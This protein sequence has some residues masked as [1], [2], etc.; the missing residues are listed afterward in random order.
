MLPS[1]LSKSSPSPDCGRG[2]SPIFCGGL[3]P[4]GLGG[5]AAFRREGAGGRAH[6]PAHMKQLS[7]NDA[8]EAKDAL[9][10][11]WEEIAIMKKLNH[12]NLVQLI[13]VLDDPEED[14][15]WMVL[16]MCKKGVVMKVGLDDGA[17]PY[18]EEQCRHWFRDLILGIEYLHAQGVI[19]RDIKPDNLLL[20]EDDVLKIVDFGVSE[21]FEKPDTMMTAKS[22]GSPAFL[23][24]ELCLAKHGDVSGKAA[25]I[26]AM[27]VT[28]YCLK[29][30]RL[31]FKRDN[32][33][34]MYEAIRNDQP[35]IPPEE[36]PK[37]RDLITRLLD[38]D[39]SRRIC[40]LEIRVSL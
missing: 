20:T 26:W 7:Q 3:P 14:S 21:L 19:H 18:P 10:L 27:G 9:F 1:R 4:R 8:A 11:I 2:P 15:L 24:P 35:E 25:D 38:K 23:P 12:P 34:D 36:G 13:E 31:P 17:D 28:L 29:Y 6:W 33:L 40:M 32:V 30:G 39:A 22:A 37:F 16:E 5:R